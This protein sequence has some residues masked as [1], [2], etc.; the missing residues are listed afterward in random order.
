M[1]TIQSAAATTLL[2]LT[3][4]AFGPGLTASENR[5]WTSSDGERTFEGRL[6]EYSPDSGQVTVIL[7]NGQ[8]LSFSEEVLSEG[9]RKFLAEVDASGGPS[10]SSLESASSVVGEQLEKT[11]LHRLD[12]R[13]YRRAEMEKT[14]EFSLLYYSA[15]W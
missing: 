9:D 12:G 11:R 1:R 8:P 2:A 4:L 10:M 14:P 13:R 6:R 7:T 5:T 15:S 3:L